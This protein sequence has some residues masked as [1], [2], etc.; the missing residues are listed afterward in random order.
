MSADKER[1]TLVDDIGEICA[2]SIVE[3][4]S[5]EGNKA[6]IKKLVDAGVNTLFMSTKTSAILEGMTVVITGTLSTLKRSEAEKLVMDN[7]GK[8]ASSVS[9]NT[10][11]LVLGENAGSKLAKAQSLGVK[12]VSEDEFIAMLEK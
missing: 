10:S 2:E 9:K 12:I 7:G 1:L 11:L 5:G 4:F 3:F 8:A 6:V